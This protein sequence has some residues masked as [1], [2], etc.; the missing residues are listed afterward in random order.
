MSPLTC[1]R[2]GVITIM[3]EHCSGC[4][5]WLCE[6]CYGFE[7]SDKLQCQKCEGGKP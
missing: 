2:C 5:L 7:V 4:D 6:C 3:L 1:D